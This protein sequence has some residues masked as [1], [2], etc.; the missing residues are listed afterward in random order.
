MNWKCCYIR[1]H[2]IITGHSPVYNRGL[3]YSIRCRAAPWRWDG[4][5]VLRIWI[6][7]SY[8]ECERFSAS[9]SSAGAVDYYMPHPQCEA[10]H[11]RL[12]VLFSSRRD[13]VDLTLLLSVWNWHPEVCSNI[14][15]DSFYQNHTSHT[16]HTKIQVV[17]PYITIMST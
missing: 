4:R 11:L 2:G 12:N 17:W 6:Y 13:I 7:L 9:L 8:G 15:S 5:D 10:V 3:E 14:F 16:I 1:L